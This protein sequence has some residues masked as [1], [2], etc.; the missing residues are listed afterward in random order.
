M[1]ALDC[2][3]LQDSVFSFNQISELRCIWQIQ[4]D[5]LQESEFLI[6]IQFCFRSESEQNKI[7][8]WWDET[9]SDFIF[10]KWDRIRF[11]FS[12]MRQ[13]QILFLW[14]ETESDFIFMKWDRIRNFFMKWD[15]TKDRSSFNEMKSSLCETESDL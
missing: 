8:F 14:N 6:L 15:E 9:E 4:I 11:F 7:F 5:W 3:F 10:M 1:S 2:D 12:K 13:N